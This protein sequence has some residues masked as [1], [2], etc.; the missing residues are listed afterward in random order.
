MRRRAA[1]ASLGDA[2]VSMIVVMENLS[3]GLFGPDM[4]S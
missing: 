1:A 2:W 3:K 4:G